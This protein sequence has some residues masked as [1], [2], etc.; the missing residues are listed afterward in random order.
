MLVRADPILCRESSKCI[1]VGELIKLTLSIL[2]FTAY[3]N[4]ALEPLIESDD[5]SWVCEIGDN[6]FLCGRHQEEDS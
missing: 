3:P 6:Q 2:E 4:G 5:Y 1:Q